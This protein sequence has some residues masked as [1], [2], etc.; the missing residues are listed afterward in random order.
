MLIKKVNSVTLYSSVSW[1]LVIFFGLCCGMGSWNL[2]WLFLK[3]K[4]GKKRD[5][6]YA[7]FNA[8]YFTVFAVLGLILT[9]IASFDVIAFP[10]RK[11]LII[12]ELE[13]LL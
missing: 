4:G 5:Q 2:H 8:V 11:G 10:G 6:D 13:E 3:S 7:M 12:D 9:P 1:T